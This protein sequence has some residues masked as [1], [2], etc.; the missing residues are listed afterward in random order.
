[1]S[2]VTLEFM[3]GQGVDAHSVGQTSLLIVFLDLFP[4]LNIDWVCV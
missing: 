2:G 3:S 1:M 4:L